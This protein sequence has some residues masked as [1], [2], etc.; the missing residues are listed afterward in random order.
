MF[1]PAPR[2]LLVDR[3]AAGEW[4]ARNR[5]RSRALFDL[6]DPS[7]Y[8]TRPI[9]LRNPVVFYEGHLP[10]FSIISF[11]NRG[12][13]RPGIDPRLEA[14]F[15]RGIDPEN[16]ETAVPRS[17]ASTQWPARDEVLTF[18]HAAD[19]LITDA[20]QHAPFDDS[21]PAMRHAEALYTALEHEAMHQETLLYMWRRLPY[22]DK[23]R[24]FY[25]RY[26]LKGDVPPRA[27]VIVPAGETTL[28][29]RRNEIPFGWDNE[30]NAHTVRV[31]AFDVDVHSVTNEDYL[32]FVEA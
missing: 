2:T 28:G 4:Y 14:L 21:R 32:P 29:A 5:S 3:V 15:A 22:S 30:F 13:G 26:D 17:G 6:I 7:A 12:L 9:A 31:D 11:V 10:A 23:V 27:S 19:A 18:G 20:I 25:L 8:Y 24:P 16:E 1:T